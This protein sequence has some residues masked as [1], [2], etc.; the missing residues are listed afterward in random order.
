MGTVR[1]Q[2]VLLVSHACV[3]GINQQKVDALA[4]RKGLELALMVPTQWRDPLHSLALERPSDS[5]YR[6]FE[7]PLRSLGGHL[8]YSQ[9]LGGYL[10]RALRTFR[11]D[12]VHIEE[13]PESVAALEVVF[14]ARRFG[15][16]VALFT[17]ENIGV[18]HRW[19][20][21]RMRRFT[22]HRVDHLI[23]GNRQAGD[24]CRR[25]GYGGPI[26]V[27]PQFG[28]DPDVFRAGSADGIR[29]TLNLSGP[30]VGFVGRLVPEKGIFVLIEALAR[31]AHLPWSML[32]VGDGPSR[33]DLKARVE[34]H[35]LAHR[36]TWVSSV[37]HQ[38]VPRYL[39]AVDVLVLASL[40][41]TAWKEQFGH[42]LIEAMACGVPV[43]GSD[44]GAIPEVIGEAGLITREGDSASL[45]E[46]L[47]RLL[48]DIELRTRVGALG[49][50]RVEA[51]FTHARIAERTWAIYDALVGA[52]RV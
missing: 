19:Y 44:S 5:A 46:T 40:T 13:E 31:L 22:L 14:W 24:V 8:N 4:R 48:A 11:P 33:E 10:V 37:P 29:H 2:R 50:A 25:D 16:R 36:L 28:V 51:E 12:I 7:I 41:G 18:T 38:E 3:V 32:V 42:V 43:V 26:S 1:P 21:G 52:G 34:A 17:W 49:R 45:A 27:I 9:V 47:K 35:G 23:A 15:A 30:V 39:Q 20:R 6:V